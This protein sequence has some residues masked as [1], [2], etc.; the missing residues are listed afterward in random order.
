VRFQAQEMLM[1]KR[2][3]K[4]DAIKPPKKE[5]IFALIDR[6]FWLLLRLLGPMVTAAILTPHFSVLLLVLVAVL[7]WLCTRVGLIKIA[8]HISWS[9]AGIV[10]G[11]AASFFYWLPFWL[12][13]PLGAVML[14]G[15]MPGL[16][17]FERRFGIATAQAAPGMQYWRWLN[18]RQRL[19]DQTKRAG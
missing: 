1:F 6:V 11:C 10:L 3:N 5:S 4:K 17:A 8:K 16:A 12:G 7:C 19:V 13:V 15:G 2:W 18:L 14:L 9:M